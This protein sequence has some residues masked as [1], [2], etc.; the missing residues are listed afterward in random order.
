MRDDA[1]TLP[2]LG[3]NLGIE[4]GQLMIVAIILSVG[5]VLMNILRVKQRDW[6]VFVSGAAAGI[7]LVLMSET[8]FW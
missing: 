1:I 6:N 5:F 2:L 3:F 4:L 8:K 7:A